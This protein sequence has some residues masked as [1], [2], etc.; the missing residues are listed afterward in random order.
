MC[1]WF[2]F[3]E[4]VSGHDILPVPLPDANDIPEPPMLSWNWRKSIEPWKYSDNMGRLT[5]ALFRTLGGPCAFA[6]HDQASRLC[7]RLCTML[8]MSPDMRDQGLE[9]L[10][11][12][13][14]EET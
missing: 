14:R 12:L 2:L 13:L 11:C 8:Q 3:Y 4:L 9:A 5:R 1:V 10:L 6:E 7:E